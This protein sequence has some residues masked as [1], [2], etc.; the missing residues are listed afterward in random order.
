MRNQRSARYTPRTA[1][2]IQWLGVLTLFQA[3]GIAGMALIG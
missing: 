3:V 2:A 1:R